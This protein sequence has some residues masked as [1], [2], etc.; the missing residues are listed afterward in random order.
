MVSTS[1]LVAFALLSI[2]LILMPGPA[3]LFVIGRSL[4]LGRIGGL[5]S[6]VGT[7]AGTFVAARNSRNEIR[8]RF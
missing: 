2:P 5:L 6:V 7:S 4:S 3:V 8:K 1:H